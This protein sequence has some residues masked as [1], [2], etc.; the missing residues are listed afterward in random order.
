MIDF[1]R[2]TVDF[3]KVLAD[4]TRL[5]ILNLLQKSEKSSIEIQTVLNKSQS[6]V[7]QHL[8]VLGNENIIT[9]EKKENVNYYRIKNQNIFKLLSNINSFVYEINREKLK[10]LGDL[11]VFNTL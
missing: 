6:T 2:Y 4:P 11:A 5:D 9:S 8:K 3:L 1:K 7:S 10:D